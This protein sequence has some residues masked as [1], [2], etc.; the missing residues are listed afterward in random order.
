MDK[1]FQPVEIVLNVFILSLAMET[2]Y[3]DRLIL[4]K[5]PI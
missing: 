2:T 3:L 5:K 1:V 4:N